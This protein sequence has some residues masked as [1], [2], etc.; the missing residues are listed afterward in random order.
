[1]ILPG[2]GNYSK[3]DIK[4]IKEIY[5]QTINL[6]EKGILLLKKTHSSIDYALGL[7]KILPLFTLRI[8]ERLA[9]LYI[10]YKSYVKTIDSSNQLNR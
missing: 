2:H 6:R 5:N 9:L 4:L 1:L 7:Q 8:Q 10:V 3:I